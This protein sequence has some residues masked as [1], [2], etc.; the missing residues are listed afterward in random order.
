M[1]PHLSSISPTYTQTGCSRTR[2]RAFRSVG[3][4]TGT[5]KTNQHFIVSAANAIRTG[6]HANCRCRPGVTLRARWSGGAGRASRAL[7]SWRSA[8][9]GGPDRT[10]ATSFSLRTLRSDW[11]RRSQRASRS[12]LSDW[13]LRTD[14]SLLALCAL[15]AGRTNRTGR[16]SLASRTGRTLRSRASRQ[17]DYHDSSRNGHQ[18]SHHPGPLSA[19]RKSCRSQQMCAV[20]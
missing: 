10:L 18:L 8:F 20:S 2:R 3:R 17:R 12:L 19:N 7:R 15:R 5:N 1:L 11:S 16:A 13:A 6:D 4:T 9:A 14:G